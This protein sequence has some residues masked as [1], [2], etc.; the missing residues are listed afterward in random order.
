MVGKKVWGSRSAS[1]VTA[2]ISLAVTKEKW[3]VDPW[4]MQGV[5]MAAVRSNNPLQSTI[6]AQYRDFSEWLRLHSQLRGLGQSLVGELRSQM[7]GI[8]AKKT[9]QNLSITDS[10]LSIYT[11]SVICGSMWVGPTNYRSFIHVV[12]TAEENG[13]PCSSNLFCSRVNST[14]RS[15]KVS[16]FVYLSQGCMV[17]LW[18]RSKQWQNLEIQVSPPV[19]NPNAPIRGVCFFV[20]VFR[21]FSP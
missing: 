10:Q 12:F 20:A 16:L 19:P 9:P 2:S 7:P 14:N 1:G 18:T 4:T 11:F 8:A 17:L 15:D 6:Q 21:L 5:G 3:T 13:K